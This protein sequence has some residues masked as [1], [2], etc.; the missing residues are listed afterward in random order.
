[1]ASLSQKLIAYADRNLPEAA[2]TDETLRRQGRIGLA[3]AGVFLTQ[4]PTFI[5]VFS[6]VELYVAAAF[7]AAAGVSF[8]LSPRVMKRSISWGNR[9]VITTLALVLYGVGYHSGGPRAPALF[10]TAAL[11]VMAMMSGTVRDGIFWACVTV[12]MAG[13]LLAAE[14]MGVPF[15]PMHLTWHVQFFGLMSIIMLIFVMFA[16][17]FSYE[18]T[19]TAM[20]RALDQVNQDMHL[21]LDNVEQGFVTVV[22]GGQMAGMRSAITSKWFGEPEAG[23]SIAD[24][25][26]HAHA[27]TGG[28]LRMG[29]DEVFE[30]VLPVEVCIDQLPKRFY[31]GP[32]CYELAYRPVFAAGDEL[33]A[34]VVIISDATERVSAELAEAAQRELIVL[35]SHLARDRPGVLQF[36]EESAEIVARLQ[37]PGSSALRLVHTLKGNAGIFGLKG[38][39]SICHHVESQA[40]DEARPPSQE[41]LNTIRNAW[42]EVSV[43]IAPLLADDNADLAIEESDLAELESAIRAG[44]TTE[45]LLAMTSTFRHERADRIFERLAEQASALATRMGRCSVHPEVIHNGVRFDREAWAPVWSAMVHAVRNAV[46][47]GGE[48]REERVANGKPAAMRIIFQSHYDAEGLVVRI[49][50]DGAGIDWERVRERARERGLP[51]ATAADLH[52]ALFADGVS[53]REE[54][55][56]LSGRG[57]GLSALREACAALGAKVSIQSERGR[58]TR[59]EVQ[60]PRPTALRQTA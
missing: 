8:L 20:V 41:E 14:V 12:G 31:V 37:A 19:R 22:R 39:A 57:V 47:H 17:A 10:W 42:G 18:S 58:G 40:Q 55:S 32:R 2:R 46:D 35:F 56:E 25:L 43:R 53:T 45:Q 6:I 44:E 9:Y 27:A 60:A 11:P 28:W 34:L 21:V 49:E 59:L 16:L 4:A 29:L 38:L 1:M 3:F 50:D 51:H 52:E 7:V 24:W 54:V 36:L 30:A 13:A 26:S 15:P 33:R 48:A 23:E 5:A